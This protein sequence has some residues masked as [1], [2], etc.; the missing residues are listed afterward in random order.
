[1]LASR[2]R[3][4]ED[5]GGGEESKMVDLFCWELQLLDTLMYRNKNQHGR[6]RY[7]HKMEVGTLGR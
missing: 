6:A 7:F 3:D 2:D 5:G 4:D 1:M